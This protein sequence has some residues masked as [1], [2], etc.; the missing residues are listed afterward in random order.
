MGDFDFLIGNWTVANRRLR[1]RLAGCTEWDEFEGSSV[2]WSL[3]GGG[4]NI[5]QFTFPDGT[6]ALTLR[7]YEPER[8]RWTL[9][10]AT[11]T[12]GVLFPPTIGAF[13]DGVGLF[14][15]DDHHEGTPVRVRFIWS[16]I[17]PTSARWEQAFSTDGEKT[18]ETNWIME[19]TRS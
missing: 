8:E 6:T 12:E 17:T 14:Y 13:T 2:V 15:G 5:D 4:A 3:L 1:Q 7:L 9:N 16:E 11:S 18:W 10:W 19:L